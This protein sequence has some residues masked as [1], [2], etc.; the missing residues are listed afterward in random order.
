MYIGFVT[1]NALQL[2]AFSQ[3]LQLP[4]TTLALQGL[5]N[6]LNASS[7]NTSKI[8]IHIKTFLKQ[9]LKLL[10]IKRNNSEIV[11]IVAQFS[12]LLSRSIFSTN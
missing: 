1:E 4:Q 9:P 11:Q 12:M 10:F 7:K 8:V 2:E 6:Y 5:A 3:F